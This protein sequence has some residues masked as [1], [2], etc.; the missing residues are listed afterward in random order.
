MADILIQFHALPEEVAQLIKQCVLDFDLCVAAIKWFPFEVE[1]VDATRLDEVLSPA[2][3]YSEMA[4]STSGPLSL[5]SKW[6][7]FWDRN[8]DKMRITI[9]KRSPRGLE[10][11][12]MS[13]RTSDE[14][15]LGIWRQVAKRLKAITQAGAIAVN[16]DTGATA[17]VRNHR[18]TKGAKALE[19]EG[20][21]ILPVA[22]GCVLRL[23]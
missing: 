20:V 21:P 9:G 12:S 18:F 13:A 15:A 3:P 17:K 16:P 22:G 10:E 4:L 2:S 19:S 7:E 8:P 6:G 11:S 14:R 1:N 23:D 5:S